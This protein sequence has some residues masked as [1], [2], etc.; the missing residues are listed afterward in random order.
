MWELK[1]KTAKSILD[2]L[3]YE[4]G[5]CYTQTADGTLKYIFVKNA[6]S[7]A[8]HT[9]D[10]NDLAGVSFTHTPASDLF[11][12]VTV[13]YN[14]H[15]ARN[16]YRSQQT[17]TDSTTRSKYNLASNEGKY[18][19]NLDILN[20]SI[21]DDITG[22]ENDPNDGFI[23]YYGN[24]RNRPRVILSAEIVNPTLFDMELGDICTFSNMIPTKAF[25]MSFS[26]KYFMV[27][28]LTRSSGKLQ[29]EF[30][31]VTTASV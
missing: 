18:T 30:T 13:N 6:Y 17:A 25:N 1:H 14:P 19:I 15:P 31:D 26:S 4:G 11:T 21:G 16:E 10:K 12:D 29:A 20:S 27:T 28:S 23:E 9:L 24:L 5:F 3:A 2:K 22:A 8:N 7:S